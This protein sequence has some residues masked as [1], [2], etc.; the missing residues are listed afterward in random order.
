MKTIVLIIIIILVIGGVFLYTNSSKGAD[1]APK[2]YVG[3]TI[4]LTKVSFLNKYIPSP[5]QRVGKITRI[6]CTDICR[7]NIKFPAIAEIDGVRINLL[8]QEFINVSVRHFVKITKK[9][10]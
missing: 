2:F 8:G 5:I 3:D 10:L 6:V 7:Y 4:S 1:V 9:G